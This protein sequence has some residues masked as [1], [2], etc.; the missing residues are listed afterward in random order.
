MICAGVSA[1]LAGLD[2]IKSGFTS[3][4]ANRVPI[5]GAS[6]WPRASNG[7]SLSGNAGSSRLDLAWRMRNSV[8]MEKAAPI[9]GANL[10][11]INR[12][13]SRIS[14][15]HRLR[16]QLELPLEG[17]LAYDP[18]DS[19]CAATTCRKNVRKGDRARHARKDYCRRPAA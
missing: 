7:R 17:R 16:D 13:M 4:F 18:R 2:R 15:L 1:R 12:I 14:G 10:L 3:R 9:C 19:Q 11:K 8:F 6:R 5:F